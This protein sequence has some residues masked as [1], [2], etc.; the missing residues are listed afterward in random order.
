MFSTLHKLLV[1][2]LRAIL[3]MTAVLALPGLLLAQS[4]LTDDAQTS[5]THRDEDKN[6]GAR[7][8]LTVSSLNN[9]YIKFKLSSTL[10]PGTRGADVARA[11]V[12]L[13]IGDIARAGKIDIYQVN[14]GWSE[15]AITFD[16]S[17]ARGSLLATTTQIEEDK[18]DD[19]LVIDVTPAVQQWLG[20]D[21]QG[22]H[23]APNHGLVLVA[24][25]IDA[26]TPAVANITF[27]SK[28]NPQTS[29]EPQLLIAMNKPGLESVAHDATLSGDGTSASPLGAANQGIGTAQLADGAV[30]NIKLA[31]GTV[32]GEKIANGAVTNA[33][34]A[35]GTVTGEKIANGAV[36]G[37]KIAT[38]QVLKSLNGLTDS[39]T[40]QTGPNITITPF[41]NTLTIDS[42][43]GGLSAVSHNATLTGDGTSGS[44]L[45]VFAPLTLTGSGTEAILSVANTGG[46]AAI[47]AAGP[48]NTSTQYNIG[49][50]RV[51]SIGGV[52]NTFVGVGTGH[53]NPSGGFNSFFGTDAG[54]N[55]TTG[56]SNSF[57]G[58]G[59]G[60]LITTGTQNS[61]F[62]TGAGILNTTG[63][64]N[65]FFGADA[66][67]KNRTGVFNSFFGEIAGFS[68]ITG[69]ANVFFGS[70]AGFSNTE[71]SAN[72]F[73]GTSAG[74]FNT[75]GSDNIFV[76]VQAGRNNT[77][78]FGNS[79]LGSQSGHSNTSENF[80]TFLGYS[81]NGVAGIDNATAIGANA[82]VT[83]SNSVVLGTSFVKVGIGTS[84][85]KAKLHITGG[86]LYLEANGQGLIL[87]SSNGTCV[88]LTVTDAG[89]LSVVTIPCP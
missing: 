47:A 43:G 39:V 50:E 2:Q 8:N 9:A 29:H 14:G 51:F 24:H 30:V 7:A 48:I 17:P 58:V 86:K 36:T 4:A 28:E 37:A 89:G 16:N 74:L 61:F 64:G 73:V 21:G 42:N 78:S 1:L 56:F 71:G 60:S 31:D 54:F 15:S 77:T 23:G 25:P 40:L 69:G 26:T 80:N 44:P 75:T 63:R 70:Q 13:Y 41:G 38:G 79:F 52:N 82:H 55:V 32:T 20:D 67:N 81:A 3:V 85:P 12:K 18:K 45:G 66:G 87:K 27:D 19:F 49:G 6:F 53:V 65:A 46:G 34:L 62:G 10:P 22:T 33:K 59:A 72:V 68:N 76:G 83:Q 5:G 11:T 57:F 88:E 84:A 35:D